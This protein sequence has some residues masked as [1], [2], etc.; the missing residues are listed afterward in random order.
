MDNKGQIWMIYVLIFFII[1]ITLFSLIPVWKEGLDLARG[2]NNGLNCPGTPDFNATDYGDDTASQRLIRRP[3][4]FVSG[5]SMIYF[6]GAVLI[7]AAMWVYK[8][9]V[10]GT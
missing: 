5:I 4:C 10:G 9:T 8:K 2:A 3:P 1:V 7:V 6:T